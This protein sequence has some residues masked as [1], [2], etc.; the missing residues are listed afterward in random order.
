MKTIQRFLAWLAGGALFAMMVLTFV[1]VLGRKFFDASITGSLE[2][3][4]LLMLVM[5][6]A[7]LPLASLAGEHVVFDLLD[8]ALPRAVRHLQ[9]R[10]SN[11]ICALLLAPAAWLTFVRAQRTLEQGDQT[12]QLALGLA[13]FQFA[14]AGLIA[15]TALMHLWLMVGARREDTPEI[16]GTVSGKLPAGAE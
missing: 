13:P 10:L 3:T 5:I 12:A 1:D 9:H 8:R 2:I 14:A 15:L 7:G 11:A 4:E 6:F 16:D